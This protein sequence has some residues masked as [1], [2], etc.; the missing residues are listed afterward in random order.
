M[1][2]FSQLAAIEIRSSEAAIPE[3]NVLAPDRPRARAIRLRGSA[4]VMAMACTHR[5]TYA[6]RDCLDGVEA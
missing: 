5:K 3:Y 4:G 2:M 6:T 1:P